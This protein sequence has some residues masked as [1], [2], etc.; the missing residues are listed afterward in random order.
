[1]SPIDPS[2]S[3]KL[4]G[5]ERKTIALQAFAGIEPI[6]FLAQRNGV[7]RPTVYRQMNRAEAA[8]DELFSS[9]ASGNNGVLFM[10]PVTRQFL[11]QVILAL[12]LTGH[13][14]FRGVIELMRDLLGVPISLAPFTTSISRP[15]SEPCP[16]PPALIS[17]PFRSACT[18]SFFKA[19]NR[20][21]PAW[22]SPQLTAICWHPKRIEMAI[23]EPSI[24]SICTRRGSHPTTR[25][26]TLCQN[27]KGVRISGVDFQSHIP[28][29][30]R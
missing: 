10:L 4:T 26:P 17:R 15:P 28:S 16:S 25:L 27:H 20:F 29:L 23:P 7:S 11:E 1:M 12:T 2:V 18:T 8:L 5:D 22:M 14:S 30:I 13:A 19:R 9:A 21:L 3:R 6:S 24:C